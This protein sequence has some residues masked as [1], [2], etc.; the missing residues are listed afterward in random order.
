MRKCVTMFDRDQK[1]FKVIDKV[2][3]GAEWAANG[4]G[5][6]TRKWDGTCCRVEGS[7]LWKRY[8]GTKSKYLPP[9]FV[10]ADGAESHWLGWRPVGNGPEDRWHNEAW[11]NVG[12]A[13]SDFTYELLGPAINKNPEGMEIHTF[14]RHGDIVYQDTPRSFAALKE[15]FTEKD[16]E[17]VVFHHPDGRMVKIKLKDFGLK[18]LIA[19]CSNTVT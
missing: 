15:W 5:I 8:D 3:I 18:R 14:R 19:R 11:D 4:E 2:A 7:R 13:L 10:H 17:G 1:T 12:Q 16:I 9:D 6:A